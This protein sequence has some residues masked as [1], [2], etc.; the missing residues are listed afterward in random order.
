MIIDKKGRFYNYSN[1]KN[2]PGTKWGSW[3]KQS[4]GLEEN[5]AALCSAKNLWIVLKPVIREAKPGP[6]ND[7]IASSF[8][9]IDIPPLFLIASYFKCYGP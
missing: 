5:N 1:I 7:P 2:C 3:W 6:V 4:N 8:Q 9:Q